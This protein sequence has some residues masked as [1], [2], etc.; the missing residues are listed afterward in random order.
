[1][2]FAGG[3][4]EYHGRRASRVIQERIAT[5][6]I[7]DGRSRNVIRRGALRPTSGT[8]VMPRIG[9]ASTCYVAVT[10]SFYQFWPTLNRRMI[11]LL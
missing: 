8:H 6:M 11:K 3:P 9:N 1:M 10:Q 7:V 5:Q 4:K 2:L